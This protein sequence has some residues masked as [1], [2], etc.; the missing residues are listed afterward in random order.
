M[1]H[2]A[3]LGLGEIVLALHMQGH[4]LSS[5]R[6]SAVAAVVPAVE[7]ARLYRGKGGEL[8]RSAVCR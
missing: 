1:R 4:A 3:A 8:M 2:G 6:Q 7:K 5:D